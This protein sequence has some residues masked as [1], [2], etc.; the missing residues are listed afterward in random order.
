MKFKTCELKMMS[1][2]RYLSRYTTYSCL[3]RMHGKWRLDV[4]F[5]SITLFYFMS[6][7]CYR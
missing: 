6:I 5:A 2:I 3:T 7:Y 4:N 1:M